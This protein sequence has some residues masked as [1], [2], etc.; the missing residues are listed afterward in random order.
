MIAW[1]IITVIMG[2]TDDILN[3]IKNKTRNVT[4]RVNENLW[5]SFKKTCAENGT[6]PTC[7]IEKGILSYLDYNKKL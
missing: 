6:K 1:Y 7:V 2:N 4:L 3:L 5:E